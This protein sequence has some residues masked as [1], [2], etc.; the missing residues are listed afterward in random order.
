[1]TNTGGRG[2]FKSTRLR[3]PAR[4]NSTLIEA[5]SK[6]EHIKSDSISGFTGVDF[7]DLSSILFPVVPIPADQR[8]TQTVCSPVDTANSWGSFQ[9]GGTWSP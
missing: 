7:A 8:D 3:V 9:R 1:M 2:W 5:A 4:D 6:L